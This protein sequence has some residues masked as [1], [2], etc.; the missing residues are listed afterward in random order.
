MVSALACNAKVV[1]AQMPT[2]SKSNE[3]NAI[4]ALLRILEL[5]GSLVSIDAIA[6]RTST[7]VLDSPRV[8]R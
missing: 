4:R 1:L 8:A 6:L 5:K 3:L 7:R 2:E